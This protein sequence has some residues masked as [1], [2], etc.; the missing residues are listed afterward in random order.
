M[1]INSLIDDQP[2]HL[3]RGPCFLSL[4]SSL[5]LYLCQARDEH[6]RQVRAREDA[7]RKYFNDMRK[8]TKANI[9][10]AQQSTLRQRREAAEKARVESELLQKQK[11][12]MANGDNSRR[13]KA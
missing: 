10:G 1:A 9:K 8:Q 7:N 2:I 6:R 3:F 5:S 13:T 11:N 4:S 12:D